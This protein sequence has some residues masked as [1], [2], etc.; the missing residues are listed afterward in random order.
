[1]LQFQTPEE[2]N[3]DSQT[4]KRQL[5]VYFSNTLFFGFDVSAVFKIDLHLFI[6][7]AT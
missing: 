1:M 3:K 4:C 2:V 7:I 5:K 6:Y